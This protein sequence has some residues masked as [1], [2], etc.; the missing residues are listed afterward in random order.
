MDSL[1][2]TG[3][4]KRFSR[5]SIAALSALAL[6]AGTLVTAPSFMSPQSAAA[7]ELSGGIRDKSG[8]VEKA[9]QK[10]SDLPAGSCVVES[11][12][13]EGSQAGFSW[14]TM[15][16]SAT[17]PDKTAWG[18]SIAFD[19]SQDRT[20]A[21]W[22]FSNSGLLAAVLDAGSVPSA[23]IGQTFL[24]DP[25]TAKAD[26]NLEI[27]ASRTQRNLNLI[28]ELTEQKVKQF[29]AAT[30]DSPVR[31]AWQGKYTKDNVNGLKA[32]QG[33]NALFTAVVNPWPNENIECNPITVSWENFQKHVIV[34]GEDTKVGKINIPAVQDGGTDDSL[35]RMVVEAYDGNG[36]FIGTTDT[37]AS[38]G[39]QM[40]RIDE[41]TGEIYFTWPPYRDTDLSDDRNVQFAVLAKPR[42]VAQLQDA[43]NHNNYDVGKAFESSNSLTR[44]NTP[45]MIDSKAFSLDDT[46]YHNPQY[47]KTDASIISGVD[48]ATGPLATEPQKVTFTQT[49]D[50]IKDLAKKK[51]DGGFEATVELDEKYVYEGWTVEI[52][53]DYNVTVTAPENP[54][55]GTFARPTV[56]VEYSNGSTDELQLLVVVDPNNTQVTDLVRPDLSKGKVNEE[57]SAQILTKSIMKGHLPV[58]PAK[59][60]IDPDSVPEGWTVTV[61]NTGKV[62]AKADDSVAPG[63]II[64]P[65]LKAT[66]PDQ[67]T[68]EI[69]VQFQAFAEIKIPDYDTVTGKPKTKVSLLPTIPERGLSGNTTD[70][71]PDRYTFE[72]GKTEAVLK[73]KEGNE[74]T[75]TIDEKTGEITTTIP[76]DAEEGDQLDVPV[77][78]HYKDGNRF[79][80]QKVTGTVVVIKGD[81]KAEYNVQVTG[82]NQAVKHQVEG[83]PKGSTYSFGKNVDGSP[84]T[85]QEVDGWK[86]QIDPNTG[87]VTATPPADAKPGDK[88]TVK[89]T[90][91]APG[92]LTTDTPVTT[93]VKLMNNWEAN[94]VIPPK[95]VYPG[96]QV[97]SQLAL[98]KPE[99]IKVAADNPYEIAPRPDYV[100]ATGEKND[101]GNPTYTLTTDNG[102]WIVSLDDKGNVI[103]TAPKTA[104]PGDQIKVPVRVTYEDGSK[105]ETFAVINVV[106]VPTREV[107]FGVEYKFDNSIPA[108]THKVETKGVP[109]KEKM[110]KDGNWDIVEDPVNEVVVIGTKPSEASE[111]VTW[112]AQI[113]FEVETRPNPK[114]KPGEIKIVQKGVPGEKTYTADFT[115]KGNDAT[116]TPE[117]KQTKDPVKEIIE[118]GPAPEDTEVVTKVEKPVPFETK[119]VFDDTLEK[120]KQVVDQTGELGTDLV[121]STQKIKDGKPDGD[122]TV[123]TERT[124]DPKDQIIRVGT[125][126][127]PASDTVEWTEKTPFEVEVRVNPELK[128]GEKKVIQEGKQGEIKHTVT[129]KTENGQVSKEESSEKISDPVKHIVEVGPN[130]TQTELTD[131]HKEQIPYETIIEYDPNLEAGKMVEDQAGELGEKE[132]TKTWQLENGEP[133]GDPEVSEKVIKDPQDRKIRVGTKCVCEVPTDPTDPSDPKDPSDKP[134]DKPVEPVNPGDNPSNNPSKPG[135]TKQVIKGSYQSKNPTYT[136]SSAGSLARTGADVAKTAYVG[137]GMIGAG[138]V[139]AVARRR[140]VVTNGLV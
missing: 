113:P 101:Y 3:V 84:I 31:Y 65:K 97:T 4:R 52:D 88:K 121:T 50:L 39:E 120:G 61:D 6:A 66:Y 96:D 77:I 117:E 83:A 26:E 82:P 68:D 18:L 30:A 127:P 46:E 93:V 44:Y 85:E 8:A 67:T 21:D 136:R 54:K 48:S 37:A 53:E 116:V 90:V 43:V 134:S 1:S 128:P 23:D 72:D 81:L 70:E 123:T 27:T 20:F 78:A 56:K 94:P 112:T 40:L 118:Y 19:N 10:A 34:P 22:S 42:T 125:K 33:P 71:A 100:K 130:K 105:D 133:V 17:S 139:L 92:G 41:T 29:S 35:S 59:F 47:D 137:M 122:P 140:V 55:P 76:S 108:G 12:E 45:N 60:E 5:S 62:T 57:I 9:A 51:G 135:K 111:K 32:T 15:E 73:D 99:D 107:P 58:P 69:E 13:P 49:S 80:P 86:Y 63:T 11:S 119:I 104:K 38:G 75:V 114:L 102:D 124:K 129:V 79:K 7:A 64:T 138:L 109:G 126:C 103:S 14:K 89:V 24:S 36:K 2:K 28:S 131:T 98:E 91:D 25:V 95:T 106:D 132:I 110:N 87:E 74:W 16:P 115:S